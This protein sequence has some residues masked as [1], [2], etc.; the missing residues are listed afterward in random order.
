MAVLAGVSTDWYARL[1]K[2]HIAEI[3]DD[4]LDA[5]ARALRLDD[6]ESAYLLDLA[7]AARPA[8]RPAPGGANPSPSHPASNGCWTR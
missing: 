4:V 8:A 6:E 1:E 7:R 5:V 3:S 2:G